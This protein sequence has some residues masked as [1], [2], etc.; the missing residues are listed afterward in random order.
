MTRATIRSAEPRDLEAACALLAASGLPTDDVAEHFASFVVASRDGRLVGVAGLERHGAL[1]LVR[2]VAVAPGLRGERLGRAL[3]D[4]LFARAKQA[5]VRELHLLT[6]HA[7]GFFVQ[8]G[9]APEAREDAPPAIR[10][11]RQFTS[12]CP[13]SAQLM[14]RSVG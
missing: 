4:E 13:A 7:A 8:L 2:S 12:L 6:E 1:G 11:T 10:A 3:C 5:G 14:R 9:F